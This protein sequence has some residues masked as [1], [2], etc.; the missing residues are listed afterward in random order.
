MRSILLIG[1][2]MFGQTL[3]EKLINMGCEVMIVDRNEDVINSL[4]PKYTGAL[5]ANCMHEDNLKTLDIPSFDACVVAIG[6]DFQSSLEIT[7]ILKDLGAKYV[8]SKASTDI[9]RKFLFRIGAD[10][11]IYPNRDIAE[12]LAVKLNS[13]RVFDYFELDSQ[14][15]IFE[16]A[17]PEAWSGQTLMTVNPRGKYGINVLSIKKGGRIMPAPTANTVFEVGDHMI[18][19]GNTEEILAFNKKSNKLK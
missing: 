17:V 12:K 18:V 3:G 7:S 2:G 14:Y 13:K 11:V 8:V 5:I 4:A 1:M 16:L 6:D 10:E 19:F 15:S 9:Q